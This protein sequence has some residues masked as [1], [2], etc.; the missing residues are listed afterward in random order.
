MDGAKTSIKNIVSQLFDNKWLFFLAIILGTIFSLFF[1]SSV[2]INSLPLGSKR[3]L[4]FTILIGLAATL[5]YLSALHWVKKRFSSFRKTDVSKAILFSFAFG[6][7]L[8]FAATSQWLE[9]NNY[10]D[11]LLP[12]HKLEFSEIRSQPQHGRGTPDGK[13]NEDS[14]AT[15]LP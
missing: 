12:T 11:L 14:T 6:F 7:L 3:F 5:I 1:S 10:V 4:A 2:E 13:N 9:S 8:F 15:G